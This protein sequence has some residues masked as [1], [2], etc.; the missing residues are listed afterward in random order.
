MDELSQMRWKPPKFH[1]IGPKVKR[2]TKSCSVLVD[3]DVPRQESGHARSYDEQPSERISQ[4]K[5]AQHTQRTFTITPPEPKTWRPQTGSPRTGADRMTR[6]LC[7]GSRI[8]IPKAIRRA[9][10][11][12]GKSACCE[13]KR[14]RSATGDRVR[15][16]CLELPS[17]PVRCGDLLG[18]PD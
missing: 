7:R 14:G 11:C 4:G 2:I 1:A 18:H 8:W 3:A 6:R 16:A 15:G 9:R 10:A 13:P 12:R 5:H 17:C